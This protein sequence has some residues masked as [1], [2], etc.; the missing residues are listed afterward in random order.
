MART[1]IDIGEAIGRF[2]D[3]AR[4]GIVYPLIAEGGIAL[5]LAH[6]ILAFAAALP[7]GHDAVHR[8]VEILTDLYSLCHG[9]IA[10]LIGGTDEAV[11]VGQRLQAVAQYTLPIHKGFLL[12]RDGDD[13]VCH[14]VSAVHGLQLIAGNRA[15][16][17][18]EAAEIHHGGCEHPF[19]RIAAVCVVGTQKLV[20]SAESFR[21]LV[22]GN[23]SVTVKSSK[24][25][26]V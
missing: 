6:D 2:V 9:F 15:V 4:L 22:D 23:R 13:V 17:D 7:G 26:N 16:R 19:A 14:I 12:R 1:V 18:G 11:R 8:L 3:L 21:L 25:G 20:P 24:V 5:L 10:R